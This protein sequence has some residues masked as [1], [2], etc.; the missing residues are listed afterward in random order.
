MT[1][2]PGA[3]SRPIPAWLLLGAAATVIGCA[4][5]GD[6]HGSPA[7]GDAIRDEI[8]ISE[9]IPT[10]AVVDF[11]VDLADPFATHVRYGDTAGCLD[12]ARA[13]LQEDGSF[14][15]YL[16]GS[17]PSSTVWYQGGVETDDD[18]VETGVKSATT[19]ALPSALPS[20]STKTHPGFT[21]EGYLL[22]SLIS[23]DRTA[24]VEA[25]FDPDGDYL[26]FHEVGEPCACTVRA[27]LSADGTSMLYLRQDV[28]YEA[29]SSVEPV[30][31]MVRVSLDGAEVELIPAGHAHHD[32]WEHPDGTIAVLVVDLRE[33]SGELIAGESIVEMKPDGSAE[34]VWSMWDTYEPSR[35]DDFTDCEWGHANT[36]KYDGLQ[37]AYYV[38]MAQTSTIWKIDRETGE[39]LWIL[40]EDPQTSTFTLAEEEGAWFERQHGFDLTESGVLVFDNA[41][42][43]RSRVVEYELDEEAMTARQVWEY[44]STEH[45]FTY[46]LG[47]VQRQ[48]SGSTLVTWSTSGQ[49]DIV[50]QDDEVIW[51]FNASLGT[52]FGY[53]TWSSSLNDP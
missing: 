24:F 16:V 53:S 19:G 34:T 42:S 41:S 44:S 13:H 37:D 40:G 18:L 7:A 47:D 3:A 35:Q 10:V 1:S 15:A 20:F 8:T 43:Q 28:Q 49:A 23:A 2:R 29:C 9:A 22:T 25:I 6:G 21:V 26:W 51:R 38:G 5:V 30:N 36:I 27:R 11:E 48:A 33:V 50:N 52:G 4:G 45:F 17:K 32:F 39:I 46:A 12:T 14:R 31:H